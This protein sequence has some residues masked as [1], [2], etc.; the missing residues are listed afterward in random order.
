MREFRIS[1]RDVDSECREL[2][3]EGELDLSV[4]DQ[5]QQRLD[6]A[7]A[8]EL[9]V[10]VY[11][12]QCDFIDSTGIAAI[13]R[14]HKLIANKG[15]RLLLCNPSGQVGRILAVTGLSDSGLVHDSTDGAL[16]TRAE[17]SPK[18]RSPMS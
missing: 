5:F 15:R 8:E 16:P 1:E 13:V 2:R 17:E 3:V 9:D 6:A 4:A 18:E 12:D 7:V 14:A 11:L 10:F